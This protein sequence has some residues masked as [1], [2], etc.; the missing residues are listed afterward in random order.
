MTGPINVSAINQF[1]RA[2]EL[3]QAEDPSDIDGSRFIMVLKI[4]KWQ[5]IR[6]DRHIV[7]TLDELG[8]LKHGVRTAELVLENLHETEA[9]SLEDWHFGCSPQNPAQNFANSVWTI[10]LSFTAE[11]SQIEAHHPHLKAEF[12][13]ERAAY[14]AMKDAAEEA[15]S[16]D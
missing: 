7:V 9:E 14:R 6:R 16:L 5:L 11:I 1:L 12:D 8:T 13:R 4:F 2:A 15:E 3:I 10:I